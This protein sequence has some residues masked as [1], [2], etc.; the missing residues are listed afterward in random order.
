[1]KTLDIEQ[2]SKL[3]HV[4]KSTL[5]KMARE[6]L[7]PAA[8]PARRWVFIESDLIKYLKKLSKVRTK[9]LRVENQWLSSNVEKRGGSTSRRQ[10]DNAYA[11]LLG[12]PK[13]NK[14]KNSTTN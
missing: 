12:L 4:S 14:L 1:M 3:L 5:S 11:A 13:N 9:K 8:K 6:G 2:A 10:M 7:V